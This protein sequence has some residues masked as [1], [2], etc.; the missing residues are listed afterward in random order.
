MTSTTRRAGAAD[1]EA[2]DARPSTTSTGVWPCTEWIGFHSVF[3]GAIRW[4]LWTTGSAVSFSVRNSA[5][6]SGVK[7]AE[8]PVQTRRPTDELPGRPDLTPMIDIVFNLI[9]FFLIV[10]DLSNLA[11]EDLQL[12]YADQAIVSKDPGRVLQLNVMGGG[13][14]RVN[15]LSYNADSLARFLEIEAAGYEYEAPGDSGG[16]PVSKL[17]VN[18]RADKESPFQGVQEALDANLRA[19]ITRTSL[20]ASKEAP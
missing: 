18:I 19:G 1:S 3:F 11:V 12:S 17:R 9:I 7:G 6:P 13:A 15:G 4:P 20:G 16:P 14:V 5:G 2:C 10:S 8:E